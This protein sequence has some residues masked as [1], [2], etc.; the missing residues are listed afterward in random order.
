[1]ETLFTV[2]YALKY[3]GWAPYL[4]KAPYGWYTVGNVL[5]NV[6]RN[7]F[8]LRL[9]VYDAYETLLYS[10]IIPSIHAYNTKIKRNIKKWGNT[11]KLL[12]QQGCSLLT[13]NG[14]YITV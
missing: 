2:E 1:M 7:D 13:E 4:C 12:L 6:R 3:E 10:D 14:D 9:F 8:Y 5:I 11:S